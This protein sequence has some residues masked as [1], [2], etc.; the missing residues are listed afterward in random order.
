MMVSIDNTP[1]LTILD[2]YPQLTENELAEA[3]DNLERYLTL[4]LRIFERLELE[5]NARTSN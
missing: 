1:E 3:E 2:L 4:V 5:T